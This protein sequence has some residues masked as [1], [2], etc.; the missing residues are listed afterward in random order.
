MG[1]AVY[2][3]PLGDAGYGVDD[4]CHAAGRDGSDPDEH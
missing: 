2:D 4:V 1:F 3:T